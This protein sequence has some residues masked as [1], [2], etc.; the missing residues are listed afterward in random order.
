MR[1]IIYT[2]I[3]FTSMAIAIPMAPALPKYPNHLI[4]RDEG[5]CAGTDI[6]C[7]PPP[8]EPEIQQLQPDPM[9]PAAPYDCPDSLIC[10][11][12]GK[13]AGT[14]IA[15]TP[16][17]PEPVIELAKKPAMGRDQATVYIPL[18]H[19]PFLHSH[20]KGAALIFTLHS[21][22]HPQK[23]DPHARSQNAVLRSLKS[24]RKLRAR[25]AFV[26]FMPR[27]IWKGVSVRCIRLF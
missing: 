11:D 7:I 12:D 5:K 21:S 1:T 19:F 8:T 6:A 22:V 27:V 10:K 16:P 4:C 14:D 18:L 9:R 17:P 2:A 25:R 26:G 15:C 13:C 23:T 20:Q 24:K 3:A